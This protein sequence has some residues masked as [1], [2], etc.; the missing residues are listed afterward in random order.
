M[1]RISNAFSQ[2]HPAL[3]PY[4]TLGYPT[5]EASLACVYA[6]VAAGADLIELGVPFSDPLADGPAVQHSTQVALE[7]GITPKRCLEMVAELR[8]RGVTIPLLL[9]GYYNPIYAYGLNAY[10]QDAA[11]AGVDGLIVPD[12]PMEEAAELQAACLENLLDLIPMIAPTSTPARIAKATA[13]ATGFI[14]L[15]SVTGITGERTS[16]AEGL[17]ALVDRVKESAQVPVAVGFGISTP[18]QAAEVGR[19]ADGVII[20]SAVIKAMGGTDPAKGVGD[21]LRG[22]KAG[23]S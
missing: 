10:A 3:M 18:A 12:L 5:P 1:T 14:Y 2:S 7:N 13:S 9:M 6:A 21:Y 22:I 11:N 16:L 4:I 17:K 15:V 8:R 19:I 23:L 20:G